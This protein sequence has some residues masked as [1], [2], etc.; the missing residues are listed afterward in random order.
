M[1]KNVCVAAADG[2]ASDS[3]RI[4]GKIRSRAAKPPLI[5]IVDD[6]S[7]V[8]EA[9]ESL[10]NSIGFRAESFESTEQFVECDHLR[11]VACLILDIQLPG[12]TG[13][14]LQR[15][16]AVGSVNLPI[17]F[18]SARDDER[19][20]ERVLNAGAVDFLLKPFEDESL[21]QAIDSALKR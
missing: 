10:L 11:D 20:R 16:L 12:M 15:L 4:S 18:I 8:R 2:K 19:M 13:V 1:K 3:T 17:V 21:L 9:V 7:S 6:D 14:E 5:S